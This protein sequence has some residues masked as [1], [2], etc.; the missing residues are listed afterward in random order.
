MIELRRIGSGASAVRAKV[1]SA[2]VEA[3]GRQWGFVVLLTL[4]LLCQAFP[5]GFPMDNQNTYFL[6]GLAASGYGQLSEDWLA[7]TTS[8]FLIFTTIVWALNSLGL[9]NLIYALHSL[10]YLAFAYS[11]SVLIRHA[12]GGLADNLSAKLVFLALMA[13]VALGSPLLK[14]G[15]AGQYILNAYLQPSEF[16]VLLVLAMALFVAGR[17]YS[18]YILAAAAGIFHQ[19][20]LLPGAMLVVAM[21]SYDVIIERRWRES[22]TGSLTALAAVLPVVI[23][24]MITF[25]PTDAAVFAESR[26]ILAVHRFPRHALP[27][28]WFDGGEA[29]KLVFIALGIASAYYVNRKLMWLMAVTAGLAAVAT[30][31]VILADSYVFYLLLPWRMSTVLMPLAAVAAILAMLK[32]L[33]EG[34]AAAHLAG[35]MARRILVALVILPMAAEIAGNM[36]V[37][38]GP[39]GSALA[40]EFVRQP[41]QRA[42]LRLVGFVARQ[43]EPGQLYL[44]RPLAFMS[45]RIRSGRPVFVDFKSHPYGDI[46]VVEW[47]SRLRWAE[48]LL[49]GQRACDATVVEEILDRRISH[50]ILDK[51]DDGL[52]AAELRDCFDDSGGEASLV[53]ENSRYRVMRV[54]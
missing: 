6:Q 18:A 4:L 44:H 25:S 33:F 28:V 46:E 32:I 2:A 11:C 21:A 24:S 29:W 16:G 53:Y 20:Y 5:F 26:E 1:T 12:P 30:G 54:R 10:L 36:M 47:W 42:Y 23:Y 34:K 49:S 22:I 31:I 50:I 45:L 51:V 43:E 41:S 39:A 48:A 9:L 15:L 3:A 38:G 8:P 14:S 27:A 19:S 35:K 17:R 13:F 7:T 40:F 52:N 37:H